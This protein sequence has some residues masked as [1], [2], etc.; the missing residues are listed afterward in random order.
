[1]DNVLERVDRQEAETAWK[2][3]LL[4]VDQ[5]EA[6]CLSGGEYDHG[7]V[8]EAWDYYQKLNKDYLERWGRK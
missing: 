5:Q 1:M 6:R 4:V 7:K 2:D 8:Q 3:Y